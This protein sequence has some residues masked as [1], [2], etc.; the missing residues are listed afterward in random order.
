MQ[1]RYN[2]VDRASEDVLDYCETARHRLHS[3]V[4]RSPRANWRKPGGALDRIAQAHT[5]TVGQIALAW[6]LK[7]SPVMLP[8][9]GTSKVEASRGERRGGGRSSS[10]TRSSRNSAQRRPSAAG[11]IAAQKPSGHALGRLSDAVRGARSRGGQ[12]SAENGAPA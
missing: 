7:R 6:L 2:L 9:P 5:A 1:N 8:I 11:R 3:L 4:S 10:A 12:A